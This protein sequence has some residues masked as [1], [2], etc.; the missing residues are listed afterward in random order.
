MEAFPNL[1]RFKTLPSGAGPQRG[2]EYA[3]CTRTPEAWRRLL[4]IQVDN[5]A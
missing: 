5:L 2:V 3:A 4:A 1:L